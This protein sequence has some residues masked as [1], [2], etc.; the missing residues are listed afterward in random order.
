M[1]T[2]C[3]SQ[4][5]PTIL[6]ETCQE[7]RGNKY[8]LYNG[9][10]YYG[11]VAVV[12]GKVKR[13]Y[14]HRVVWEAGNGVQPKK[15]HIHHKDGN[16]ANNS[17]DNLECVTPSEHVRLHL[18]PERLER[19]RANLRDNARPKASEWHRSAEGRKFHRKIGAMSY[20]NAK[21]KEYQ[22]IWCGKPRQTR[23]QWKERPV[24]F[25][26]LNCKMAFRKWRL[27]GMVGITYY[28]AC[29]VCEEKYK[30]PRIAKVC[31]RKCAARRRWAIAEWKA[32]GKVGTEPYSICPS[33]IRSTPSLL[34]EALS[35]LTVMHSATL[36]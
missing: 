1:E 23:C 3:P 25:C 24:K 16:R 17:L 36:S 11:R 15:S 32:S 21:I 14:L 28:E 18:T 12:D 7:F 13:F 22:C 6:S 33:I 31:G 2:N 19:M 9:S 4:R 27:R 20:R 5:D 29:S 26:G 30:K 10:H 35:Y 8:S 34:K